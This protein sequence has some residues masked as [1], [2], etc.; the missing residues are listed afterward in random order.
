MKL[1]EALYEFG[2]ISMDGNGGSLNLTNGWESVPDD[3]YEEG[4]SKEDVI[5]LTLGDKDGDGTLTVYGSAGFTG[6]TVTV[7][8]YFDES[9]S[10]GSF[11][12][13]ALRMW[14]E[15]LIEMCDMKEDA[16]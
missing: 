7:G 13:K 4:D 6:L 9:T 11:D 10:V 1:L 14:A 8:N 2:D 16:T 5:T 3:E 15:T 12:K